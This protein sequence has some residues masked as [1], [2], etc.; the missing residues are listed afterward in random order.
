MERPQQAIDR[1]IKDM[2]G[3]ELLGLLIA[4]PPG[5]LSVMQLYRSSKVICIAMLAQI[6]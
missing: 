5:C 3:Y 6:M 2:S 1:K 4:C